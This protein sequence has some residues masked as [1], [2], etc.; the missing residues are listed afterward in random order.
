[1]QNLILSFHNIFRWLILLFALLTI[2]GSVS[3]MGGKKQ[4]TANNKRVALFLLI[5]CDIQLLLGLFLYFANGWFT[6]LTTGTDV[7]TNAGLRFF[8]MEH[9]VAMII[10]IILVHIGYSATKKDIP[11]QSKFKRLFW[12]TFIALVIILASI[13][14]PFREA[15]ARPLFRMP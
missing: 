15:I 14:W 6:Q 13:P 11:D 9:N 7:M 12:F 5:S 8:A 4:F 2:V 10:A 1:M 3:G